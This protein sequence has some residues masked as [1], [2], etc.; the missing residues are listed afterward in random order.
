MPT[1]ETITRD[2][3]A[4]D[5]GA[6]SGRIMLGRFDGERLRLEERHR[7]ANRAVRLPAGANAGDAA[8]RIRL[9]WDILY[10]WS[11]ILAG[12][13]A[14]LADSTVQPV[15]LA[16]DTWGVDFGLLDAHGGLLS[17]PLC[18]RDAPGEDVMGEAFRRMP[19]AD[20]YAITGIQVMPINSLYQLLALVLDGAPLLDAARTFLTTPDL[21]NYWLTGQIASEY[22]IASTTQCLDAR[23]RTWSAPLL[24]A[25]GIPTAIFPDVIAPGTVLGPLRPGLLDRAPDDLQVIAAACHDTA[26]AVMSV[27]A[28]SQVAWISSGTWSIVGTSTPEPVITPDSQRYNIT[29]EGGVGGTYR[30]SRN[31]MG[32]WL[33]QQC[34]RTWA[35]AGRD[36]GYDELT[37][38]AADAPPL[39]AVIDPDHSLFFAPGDMPG[40]VQQFCQQT[41]QPV[42]DTPGAIV[43]CVLESLALKYRWVLDRLGMM[44]GVAWDVVHILGG[45]TQNRLLSQFT[46]DATGC[47]VITGP[48]EATAAGSIL[49]QAQAR[50]D[51]A[52]AADAADVVRASFDILTFAPGDASAWN[53]AFQRLSALVDAPPE[54]G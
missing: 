14:L 26:S 28:A 40:R 36:Y 12:L 38:L 51:L 54:L 13:N 21:L 45:G 16:V 9:H 25:M 52:S 43:R 18:Y 7:F 48:V 30:F 27:P 8:P 39:R 11:E 50:G 41:G 22:T 53:D 24:D 17:N 49:L 46:A 19:Q 10:L 5:L 33:V 15:G 29:N 20:I 4:I 2:Y 35:A 37:A 6:E 1:H 47:T 42:P 23:Q 44:R 34:R 32:L 31:V 3:V